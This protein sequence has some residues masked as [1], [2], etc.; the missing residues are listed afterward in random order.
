MFLE[1]YFFI[2][3]CL[4]VSQFIGAGGNALGDKYGKLVP[5]S[6]AL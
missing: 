5:W 3:K 2:Y 1:L 4:D 6:G